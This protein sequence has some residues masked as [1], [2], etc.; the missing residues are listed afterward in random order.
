MAQL[1]WF[2]TYIFIH[3]SLVFILWTST[4]STEPDQTPQ[5]TAFDL[6][7]HCMFSEYILDIIIYYPKSIRAIDKGGKIPSG[8]NPDCFHEDI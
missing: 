5:N 2:T 4:N 6:V 1:L 8:I 7:L 3:V